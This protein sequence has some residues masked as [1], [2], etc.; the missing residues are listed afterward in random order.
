[1][2]FKYYDQKLACDM[3]DK[4]WRYNIKNYKKLK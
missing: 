1:M 2:L 4:E 3:K